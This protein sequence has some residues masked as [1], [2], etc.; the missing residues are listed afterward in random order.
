MKKIRQTLFTFKLHSAELLP[1]ILYVFLLKLKSIFPYRFVKCR[2]ISFAKQV[3]REK[4][5]NMVH[6]YLWGSKALN[7]ANNTVYSQ[8]TGFVGAPHFRSMAKLLGYQGIAVVMEE[9][10]KIIKS[11]IQGN[12]LQFTRTL[13]EAM[14]KQCKL[15]RYDYGSPGVLGYYQATL[16]DIVQYPDARTEL[17]HNFRELGNAILFCLLMEQA[18]SQEEVMDL[19]HAA[20]FQ[21]ILPRPFCKGTNSENVHS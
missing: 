9:L 18:L 20:A 14:P 15:P 10:L 13:M 21:N 8:Y 1:F 16:Q 12:I 6:H 11:L 3:H 19:L 5:P 7:I 2:D 17:F 4:A